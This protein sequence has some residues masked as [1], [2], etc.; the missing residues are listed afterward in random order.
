V[1]EQELR[2][3]YDAYVSGVKLAEQGLG[4]ASQASTVRQEEGQDDVWHNGQQQ[5][6]TY[7]VS[8][9]FGADWARAVSEMAQAASA[10]QSVTMVRFAHVPSEDINCNLNNSNV[11]FAVVPWGGGLACAPHPSG[12][13]CVKRTLVIDFPDLDNNWKDFPN[14]T[15]VGVLRH[16]LGHILGLRHESVRP[17]GGEQTACRTRI[18]ISATRATSSR[19]TAGAR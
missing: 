7:C 5:S 8:N 16:E 1:T 17:E 12:G 15:T 3:R 10:W 18:P 19:S 14:L 13:G 11:V 6:L 2:D 4:Q 9:V